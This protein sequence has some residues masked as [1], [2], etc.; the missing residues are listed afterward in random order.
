MKNNVGKIL[1]YSTPQGVNDKD[2][3]RVFERPLKQ[4]RAGA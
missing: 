2:N 1:V 3:T 4:R